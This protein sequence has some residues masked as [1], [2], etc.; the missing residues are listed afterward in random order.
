MGTTVSKPQLAEFLAEKYPNYK[1]DK[2]YLL[3]G[4]FAQQRRLEKAVA[5]LF[6]VTI[7]MAASLKRYFNA[8][9]LWLSLRA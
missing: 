2:V 8:S 5:R 4:R 6:P 9:P 7:I 3:K 1:W